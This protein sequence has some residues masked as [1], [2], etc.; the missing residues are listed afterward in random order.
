M[1]TT[2]SK[3]DPQKIS[4]SGASLSLIAAV[5]A[6]AALASL[7]VLSPE[8][9]PARRM[10]SE[11]ALGHHGWL[12]SLMFVTWG[13]SAWALAF[14]IRSQVSG[15]GG[16]VGL[17]FLIAAGIGEAMASVF[18][19]SWPR[20]HGL[21]AAIGIPSLPVAAVLISVSLGRT[22]AWHPDRRILLWTA[23][24]TWMSLALL[25]IVILS[26]TP[27]LGSG[28][29]LIGWPNRLLIVAYSAWVITVAWQ[30]L[31][32]PSKTPSAN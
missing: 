27:K 20:L 9:D 23:N 18:D 12:L 8:F 29:A 10:V 14:A 17:V 5:A 28:Q 26:S 25:A 1:Q 31:R 32:V 2:I 7:H 3:S 22:Q 6:L 21:S 16:Y 24:L 4:R 13:L 11:Y 15:I 30:A 19:V